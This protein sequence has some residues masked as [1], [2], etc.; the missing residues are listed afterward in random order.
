MISMIFTRLPEGLALQFV[1]QACTG[2]EPGTLSC[3][4]VKSAPD[5]PESDNNGLRNTTQCSGSI[6][7]LEAPDTSA[8][9]DSF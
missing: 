3:V 6:G 4:V 9:P 7:N 5:N 2:I 8:L 1:R